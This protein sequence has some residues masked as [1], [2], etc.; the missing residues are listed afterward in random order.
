MIFGTKLSSLLIILVHQGMDPEEA[1]VTSA[2]RLKEEEL[3]VLREGP[4]FTV[5]EVK[6]P[7]D[8]QLDKEV[9]LY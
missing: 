9:I 4:R 2:L 6:V 1:E 8:G 7:E 5:G 3:K